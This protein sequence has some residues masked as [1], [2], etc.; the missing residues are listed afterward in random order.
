MTRIETVCYSSQRL[1]LSSLK[2]SKGIHTHTHTHICIF[3]KRDE[4]YKTNPLDTVPLHRRSV[5]LVWPKWAEWTGCWPKL[6]SHLGYLSLGIETSLS[7]W[8][9]SIFKT[10]SQFWTILNFLKLLLINI[11]GTMKLELHLAF[12]SEI[13]TKKLS[14]WGLDFE[15]SSETWSKTHD[16]MVKHHKIILVSFQTKNGIL[17]WLWRFFVFYKRHKFYYLVIKFDTLFL[18]CILWILFIHYIIL[19]DK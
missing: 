3:A 5:P 18:T 16:P 15:F 6:D 14:M 2:E 7:F 10:H 13:E 11:L 4:G 12:C 17:C 9:F 19:N 1:K 8:A